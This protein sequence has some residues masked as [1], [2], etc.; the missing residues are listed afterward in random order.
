MGSDSD[1]GAYKLDDVDRGVLKALQ[2]DARHTTAK[3]IAADVDVSPST[4]RNRIA[5][6]EDQGVIVGYRPVIDYERAGYPLRMLFV[7]T[8]PAA[9]RSRVAERLT[10]IDG[11]VEVRETATGHRNLVIEV[12]APNTRALDATAGE[13]DTLPLELIEADV[14]VGHHPVAIEEEC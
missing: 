14:V 4:V 8:T 10:A 2:R 5:N 12:V 11:V 7:A 6:M 1:A 3:E 9:E 13:L